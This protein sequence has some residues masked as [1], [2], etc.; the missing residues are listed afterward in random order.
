MKEKTFT[1]VAQRASQITIIIIVII[2]VNNNQTDNKH[3]VFIEKLVQL[4][5]NDRLKFQV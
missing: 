1:F 4:G 3:K 5:P 2:I